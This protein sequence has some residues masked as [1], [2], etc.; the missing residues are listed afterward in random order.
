MSVIINHRPRPLPDL[1]AA[2]GSQS[3]RRADI[4]QLL[5]RVYADTGYSPA[6]RPEAD[7]EDGIE[8]L[9]RLD[10]GLASFDHDRTWV[11][12][13]HPDPQ[14]NAVGDLSGRNEDA[15]AEAAVYGPEQSSIGDGSGSAHR[16]S[17]TLCYWQY[18]TVQ[19]H[20]GRELIT[21]GFNPDDPEALDL[22]EEAHRLFGERRFL[23]KPT[24][25]KK[26]PAATAR[27][28]SIGEKLIFDCDH[29]AWEW[30]DVSE[31][32]LARTLLLQPVVSMHYEYRFF[33][34]DG[35][36]VAGAGCIE[37]FTPL[38]RTTTTQ[39]EGGFDTRVRKHRHGPHS[40]AIPRSRVELV[41]NYL[42]FATEIA[43]T[44]KDEDPQL[45]YYTL[46][47]ATGDQ[48]QPLIIELNSAG[49]AGFYA[50]DPYAVAQAF[51]HTHQKAIIKEVR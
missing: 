8:E 49:A 38:N 18:D 11:R 40:T 33:I 10:A 5:A 4:E 44:L 30:A 46:D 32:G 21:C 36:P 26:R 45:D 19:T 15:P 1:S 42:R 27:L 29:P 6:H 25:A 35:T 13:L 47:L 9:L 50:A 12:R 39:L 41:S 2:L 24:A 23:V 37:E 20:A 31:E 22:Y 43:A 7:F 3:K 14:H 48:G 34:V 16:S 17:D 28:R 51:A